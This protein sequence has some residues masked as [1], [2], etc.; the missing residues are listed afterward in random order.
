VSHQPRP[1][2]PSSEG[3][4][5]PVARLV[6]SPDG[7]QL[8]SLGAA[9]GLAILWDAPGRRESWRIECPGG[10]VAGA[11]ADRGRVV[12]LASDAE[13]SAWSVTAARRRWRTSLDDRASVREIRP[14]VDGPIVGLLDT[15]GRLTRLD[16]NL[17][18]IVE[19]FDPPTDSS[20]IVA[21]GPDEHS[22][23]FYDDRRRLC[24]WDAVGR[25]LA[26]V[27]ALHPRW[28]ARASDEEWHRSRPHLALPRDG[29]FLVVAVEG[30]GIW[31]HDLV[32]NEQ[33]ARIEPIGRVSSIEL[34]G[35]GRFLLQV[36]GSEGL[37]LYR[38]PLVKP[39]ARIEPA[40][41]CE[42]DERWGGSC[43][44]PDGR[45]IVVGTPYGPLVRID[46]SHLIPADRDG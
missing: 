22:V 2:D 26:G 8:L 20:L 13:V 32:S 33:L 35:D 38:I 27:L 28:P 19:R 7:S 3:H 31:I 43:W 34:S 4:S 17:G 11:F 45:S 24:L 37:I 44:W 25:R 9:D 40:L 18:T 39:I 12:I 15:A 21:L 41:F 10:F 36:G 1:A 16:S 30:H 29:R 23:L 14:G 6:A 5:G 42:G 46:V